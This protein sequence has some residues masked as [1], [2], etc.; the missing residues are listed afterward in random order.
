MER[1]HVRRFCFEDQDELTF[2]DQDWAGPHD[3][4][5]QAAL[6]DDDDDVVMEFVERLPQGVRVQVSGKVSSYSLI[7]RTRTTTTTTHDTQHTTPQVPNT[8][9]RYS[10]HMK[11]S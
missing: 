2:E 1:S 5:F 9:S 11:P 4:L 7:I 3:A 6:T 8:T 10:H